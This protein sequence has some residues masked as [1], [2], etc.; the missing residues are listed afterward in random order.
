MNQVASNVKHAF[1]SDNAV[2]EEAKVNAQNKWK[3]IRSAVKDAGKSVSFMND[4]QASTSKKDDDGNDA[5]DESGTNAAISSD[6]GDLKHNDHKKYALQHA[7][8]QRFNLN[9]AMLDP[10]EI[11]KNTDKIWKMHNHLHFDY[12]RGYYSS[13]E[14]DQATHEHK[15]NDV[16]SPS[17]NKDKD[18]KSKR[19]DMPSEKIGTEDTPD[20]DDFEVGLPDDGTV[21]TFHELPHALARRNSWPS[22]AV[23]T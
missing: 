16:I 15:F 17:K 9:L 4:L 19:K 12:L 3:N 22:C 5:N 23:A 13:P 10:E 2:K 18:I 1:M 6:G 11:K 7:I 20:N 8:R 14:L 21:A